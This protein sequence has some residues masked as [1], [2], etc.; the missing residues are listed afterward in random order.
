[1]DRAFEEA[2]AYGVTRLAYVCLPYFMCGL[3]DLAT[4][5]LRGLGTSFIPMIVTI[6]GV[7][8]L[9]IAW[10]YTIFQMPQ[11]HTPQCL[12]LSYI[13][14]WTLTF[15]VQFVLLEV[16]LKKKERQAQLA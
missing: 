1:M 3:M 5:A 2:I 8:G 7:C 13:V 15:L 4:G 14:S 9:R 10:V 6:L 12:Y 11:F 16:V